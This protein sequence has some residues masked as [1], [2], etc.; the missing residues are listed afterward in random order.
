[1]T[2]VWGIPEYWIVDPRDETV[3]VLTLDDGASE[4]RVAG[5]YRRG[6]EAASLLLEGFR[7][8]VAEVFSQQ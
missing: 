7:A 3:T 8:S 1:M 5:T 6:D 4:Y 2:S